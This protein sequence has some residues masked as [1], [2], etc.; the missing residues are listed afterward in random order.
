MFDF[1]QSNI[2][3]K[4]NNTYAFKTS[5][6]TKRLIFYETIRKIAKNKLSLSYTIKFLLQNYY[7]AS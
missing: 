2:Q 3:K 7:L 1:Y 6:F 4:N 5:I